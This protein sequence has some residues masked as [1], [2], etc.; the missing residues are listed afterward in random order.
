MLAQFAI[1]IA[2]ETLST[3][4]RPTGRA[5]DTHVPFLS[6]LLSR[7]LAENVCHN[8]CTGSLL[9]K[10]NFILTQVF[11]YFKKKMK[12]IKKIRTWE[13]VPMPPP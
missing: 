5:G 1:V 10:I 2:F 13:S 3:A 12:K 9:V 7:R 8:T 11:T 4:L 6:F